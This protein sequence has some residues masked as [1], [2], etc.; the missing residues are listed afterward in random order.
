[1][2]RYDVDVTREDGFWVAVARGVRGGATES[3]RLSALDVQVRDLL[4]GLL[5]V[6]EDELELE[7]HVE[8]ALGVAATK[9]LIGYDR[10]KDALAV[11]QFDYEGAQRLAVQELRSADV[12]LRDSAHLLGISFQRVQ[13]LLV[14]MP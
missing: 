5:D 9:A 3:R 4:S 8:H 14:A 13:Q 6:A 1:M 11:A 10:A 2:N 12:S 7:Y